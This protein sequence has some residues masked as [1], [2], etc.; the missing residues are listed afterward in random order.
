MAL[1][2]RQHRVDLGGLILTLLAIGSALSILLL[3]VTLAGIIGML[4]AAYYLYA[5]LDDLILPRGYDYPVGR[6]RWCF[7]LQLIGSFA[8]SAVSNLSTWLGI[9]VQLI[10]SAAVLWLLWQYLQAVK[11]KE[12]V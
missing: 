2:D 6:I 3:L 9:V 1:D 11:A 5:G 4:V 10:V 7:W 12:G 8:S